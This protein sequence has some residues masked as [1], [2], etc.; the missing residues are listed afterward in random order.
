MSFLINH[1]PLRITN[2]A[3]KHGYKDLLRKAFVVSLIQ[4]DLGL[5]ATLLTSPGL[6]AKWVSS[7]NTC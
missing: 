1:D 5:V 2:H 4:P 3:Y 6:L 7:V